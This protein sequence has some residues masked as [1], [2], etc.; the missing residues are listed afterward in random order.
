MTGP[1]P[2]HSGKT[3]P[4]RTLL[5]RLSKS[6]R[7]DLAEAALRDL[8]SRTTPDKVRPQ[9]VRAILDEHHVDAAQVHELRHRMWKTAFRV[10]ASDALITADEYAYL[11]SLRGLLNIGSDFAIEVEEEVLMPK[12]RDAIQRA[13]G[14]R[15]LSE[16]EKAELVRLA[17]DMRI[18]PSRAKEELRRGSL[19][20]L[21][22]LWE[23]ANADNRIDSDEAQELRQ[24]SENLGIAFA[25]PAEARI[26]LGEMFRE[27][28]T[29]IELPT[30]AS[31]LNLPT[32][33][34]VH[35]QCNAE[36]LEMRR[37]HGYDVLTPIDHGLLHITSRR[38]LFQ[39]NAKTTS[40]EY[41]K[42]V[43]AEFFRD[44]I[45]LRKQSGRNPYLGIEPVELVSVV[46]MLLRRLLVGDSW[47]ATS[48]P[49]GSS[50]NAT[51]PTSTTAP[52]DSNVPSDKSLE[53]LLSELD[54]MVGL[55]PV[56]REIRTLVN[57]AHVRRMRVKEGMRVLPAS[58]HM[59]FS[60]PPGTGKTTVGRLV[61]G[62][63]KSLGILSKGHLI[64]VDRAE[65]VAGYVGQT[66]IKTDAAVNKALGGV[67]FIDEA[68]SLAA[69]ASGEDFGREAIE[70]LLKL[71]EDNRN[72]L[73]VIA[74]GYR[75]RMEDFLVSN[76]GLQ[77]RFARY[78]DFPDYSPDEL[79]QIFRLLAS[80]AHY[81]MSDKA[82]AA[83][84]RLLAAH[85]RAKGAAFGNA[86][87]VRNLFE[88]SIANQ[89]NRLASV[90]KVSRKEL[91]TLEDVDIPDSSIMRH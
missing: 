3:P 56:K 45:L 75:E 48:V 64:E 32:G 35:L 62:I 42:I 22:Q 57:V 40:L 81:E 43:D 58:Y 24:A 20:A 60:G 89:A 80:E 71:M 4:P 87:L 67:L 38:V 15:H 2:F 7:P 14:D 5:E 65:L 13:L 8:L 49:T 9:D 73:V 77:S 76:P 31:D 25:A 44:A 51:T 55:A 30:I 50:D 53:Q 39:G 84:E 88:E 27:V 54:A 66:A 68:Y 10:F 91:E 34:K 19:A 21:N 28:G 86:R 63:L 79:A 29:S 23:A 70:T 37:E 46:W 83:V 17:A 11:E 61:G 1:S 82:N 33:E 90:A 41:S 72:D 59:V 52:A 47:F 26:K 36:W 85:H 74:A 12:Y 78:I 69:S 16:T 18:S 6:P